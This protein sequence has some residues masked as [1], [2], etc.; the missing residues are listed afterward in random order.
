MRSSERCGA[1]RSGRS[2]PADRAPPRRP[3]AT[4]GGSP[5]RRGVKPEWPHFTPD[6]LDDSFHARFPP[7]T[8][9]GTR[10]GKRRTKGGGGTGGSC[11][12]GGGGARKRPGRGD[13]APGRDDATIVLHAVNYAALSRDVLEAA[14]AR[15]AM[16]YERIGVRIG[17]SMTWEVSGVTRMVSSTSPF[18]CS[19]ARWRRR[20]SQRT[21]SKTVCS[22]RRTCPAGRAS[23]F[24]DRIATT[25]GAPK[26]F[27]IPLGNVIAHEVGHLVL[28]ANS[29][30]RSGIMRA[31]VDVRAFH[32]QRFDETQAHT[33]RL[34]VLAHHW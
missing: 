22:A 19:R 10:D 11:I 23:I 6:L 31:N 28:G 26:Y 24:C 12:R 1:V 14:M 9:G 32:I 8:R 29:H 20:K 34:R 5:S 13:S 30:S 21:V 15:V 17:G 4:S 16:I 7:P 3:P 18:C 33:I 2:E 27:P 25:P